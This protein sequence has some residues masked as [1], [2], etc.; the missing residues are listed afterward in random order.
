MCAFVYSDEKHKA[1]E[2]PWE[3]IYTDAKTVF[4]IVTSMQTYVY[5]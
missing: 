3:D 4:M 5:Q 1:Y 2:E